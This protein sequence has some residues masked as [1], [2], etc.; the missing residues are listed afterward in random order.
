MGRSPHAHA[1]GA[2]AGRACPRP[3]AV[4]RLLGHDPITSAV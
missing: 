3:A 4:D 2:G 1:A